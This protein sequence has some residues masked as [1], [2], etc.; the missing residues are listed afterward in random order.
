M[1]NNFSKFTNLKNDKT[2]IWRSYSF[3]EYHIP[4]QKH[5]EDLDLIPS[6][7]K[8][9]DKEKFGCIIDSVIPSTA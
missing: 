9:S 6:I 8:G 4:S 1:L 2:T 3:H 5:W 7:S